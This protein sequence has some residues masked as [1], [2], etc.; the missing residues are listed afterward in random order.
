MRCLRR[1][2]PEE[3]HI[4][5]SIKTGASLC[6]VPFFRVLVCA[7]IFTENIRKEWENGSLDCMY[8]TFDSL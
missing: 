4:C 2:M 3:N 7:K 8:C 5:T 1:E 6:G